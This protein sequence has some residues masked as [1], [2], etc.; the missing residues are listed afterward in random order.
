MQLTNSHGA[1]YSGRFDG[2]K[3]ICILILLWCRTESLCSAFS[4]FSINQK[5]CRSLKILMLH[6]NKI[7]GKVERTRLVCR[8]GNGIVLE[9]LILVMPYQGS[10]WSCRNTLWASWCTPATA[11]PVWVQITFDQADVVIDFEYMKWLGVLTSLKPCHGAA[12]LTL[13]SKAHWNE[14]TVCLFISQ[15]D[16]CSSKQ[17][18]Q[19]NALLLFKWAGLCYLSLHSGSESLLRNHAQRAHHRR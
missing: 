12:E 11:Y 3:W 7:P 4:T 17:G 2:H 8:S 19:Q 15:K 10:V 16:V 18:G 6:Y 9:K 1:G 14:P 5:G 13:F